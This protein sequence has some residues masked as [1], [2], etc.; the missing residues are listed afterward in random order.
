MGGDGRYVLNG[1]WAVS[2]PGTYE[3]AGTHVV[4]TRASGPE[5]TLQAAGPTSQD[6]LLQVRAGPQRGSEGSSLGLRAR[7]AGLVF[8]E[9]AGAV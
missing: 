4:Y 6:L 3:A 8:R 5:E 2:P 1:N 7:R 9:R